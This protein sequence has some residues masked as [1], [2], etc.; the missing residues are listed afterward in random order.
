MGLDGAKR[1]ASCLSGDGECIIM[2]LGCCQLT[3]RGGGG[4]PSCWVEGRGEIGLDSEQAFGCSELLTRCR[5]V[6]IG[7]DTLA[8][9]HNY[10]GS[11]RIT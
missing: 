4:L 3:V 6:G 8:S 2:G 5:A 1:S 10:P 11:H 7:V 9:D